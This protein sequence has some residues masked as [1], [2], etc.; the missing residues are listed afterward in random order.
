MTFDEVLGQV[1]ELLQQEKRVSYRGIQRRF[2]LDEAYLADLKEELLFAHPEIAD[3]DGRGLVCNDEAARVAAPVSAPAQSKG[4]F[5]M[6]GLE[7]PDFTQDLPRELFPTRAKE[8]QSD[9]GQKP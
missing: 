1:L 6:P 3:V 5:S 4:P 9:S 8:A 7:R 2:S